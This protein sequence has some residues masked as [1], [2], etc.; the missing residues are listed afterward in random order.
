MRRFLLTVHICLF[1]NVLHGHE[2]PLEHSNTINLAINKVFNFNHLDYIEHM[3]GGFSSPGIYKISIDG[4]AY[5][6][7]FYGERRSLED[8]QR[9]S[10]AMEIAA[11]QGLAPKIHYK[12][13]IEGILIMD[14]ID[15]SNSPENNIPLSEASLDLLGTSLQKLHAGPDF[16]ETVSIFDT[17]RYFANAI[18]GEKPSIFIQ[19]SELLNEIQWILNEH[20][21][22]KPCHNDLNPNN[23]LFSGDEIYFIDWEAAGQG[24]PFFDLATPVV[25]YAM[26]ERQ[27]KTLLNGYFKR[28]LLPYEV[29]KFHKM[30]KVAMIL[31]GYALVYISQLQGENLMNEEEI[32]CLPHIEELL[33][34]KAMLFPKGIQQCGF[35]FLR[36]ALQPV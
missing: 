8:R 4:K 30:K 24:D 35:A 5:V 7:R 13:P 3:S 26:N 12:D 2:I 31:Y 17:A 1:L 11:K 15:T 33:E 9:E 6:V 21:E 16:K 34:A 27:E 20:L 28:E 14:F 23:I 10:D 32:E 22:K 18:Q 36:K 25:L 19:A 29:F